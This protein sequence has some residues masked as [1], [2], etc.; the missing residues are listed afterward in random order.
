[1]DGLLLVDKADGPT[2]HA[3]VG[4]FR[5]LLGT[6]AVGH[7]GTLDP[8]ATGLLVLAVGR[9]TRWLPYLPGDKS[10]RATLRLGV[11]TDTEDVWGRELER[12]EHPVAP[13][14]E[15]LKRALESLTDLAEQTVP[16]VSAVKHEGRRLYELARQGVQ[17]DR[18]PRPVTVS[19]VRV[20][21]LRGL[22]ADFEVDCG[23]GT[24]VRTLCV[25]AGRRLGLPACM[26][27]LR[28]L[29]SGAFRVDRALGPEAWTAERARAAMLDAATA[30]GHLP[31]RELNAAEAEDVRH[32]RAVRESSAHEGDWRL[33]YEGRLL[34]LARARAGLL[35]P[36]RV[37]TDDHAQL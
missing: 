29:G 1:M 37:F 18:A 12:L 28:R 11:A 6:R 14:P 34:A 17:V 27:A 20:L 35:G 3:V 2:S 10:Y 9:A 24:Y 16:M 30:L 19:A 4:T 21:A 32:G 5:R 13:E 7:A 25:E 26:S 23:P 36:R 22:E 15:A 8:H 31:S 33:T